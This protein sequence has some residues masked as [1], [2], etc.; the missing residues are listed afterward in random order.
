M[1]VTRRSR[2]AAAVAVAVALILT[3]LSA[4]ATGGITA[5][6]A[7]DC[8]TGTGLV[9]V[10]PVHQ[11]AQAPGIP[12][13]WDCAL[14][15]A[16]RAEAPIGMVTAE[17][18]PRVVLEG[19]VA[20]LTA[21][22]PHALNDQVAA[23]KN[24]IIAAAARA[25][26]T[27]D[28]NDLL[29]ALALA[30]DLVPG[31]QIL[32][33]DNGATDTGVLRTADEGMTTLVAAADVAQFVVDAGA[34]PALAGARVDLYGLGYQVAPAEPISQRQ[35]DLVAATW[36]AVLTECGAEAT[37]VPLPRT[38]TGPAHA[39]TARPI[40]PEAAPGFVVLAQDAQEDCEAVLP[41]SVIGFV[42]DEAVFL[43]ADAAQ[44][45]VAEAGRHLAD[46]VGTVEVIGT[47]SSAGSAAGREALSARRAGA[48][49]DLLA[50]E[51]GIP[52]EDIAAHGL[53][54]DTEAGGCVVDRVDGVLDPL[55]AARN[56]KV[57]IRIVP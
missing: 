40:R 27:S 44:K 20:S 23:A 26:A 2:T 35:R 57:V 56:R 33:L 38:G 1:T 10:V 25:S 53:G 48:V 17:G 46:C 51:L 50:G 42:A 7:P 55:L 39:H 18:H 47:T 43:S 36:V 16:L 9:L 8:F 24:A 41:D 49:R 28:G 22:N 32:S 37:A 45:V 5:A 30:A 13:E 54:Y 19:H 34:C 21:A 3:T 29:A 12:S 11:N 6:A 31:A 14:D 15:A 52:V 4:C